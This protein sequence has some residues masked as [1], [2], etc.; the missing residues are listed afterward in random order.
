MRHL[1][2]QTPA[3]RAVLSD[4]HGMTVSKLLG[5]DEF[6]INYVAKADLGAYTKR[7]ITTSSART[8][9]SISTP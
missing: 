7:D 6:G 4:L 2:D 9:A 3:L 5:L 8:T 1:A